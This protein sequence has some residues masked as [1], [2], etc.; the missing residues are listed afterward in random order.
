MFFTMSHQSVFDITQRGICLSDPAQQREITDL[1]EAE[2]IDV[3]FLDNGSCLFRGVRENDADDFSNLI[4]GWLMDLRR[5]GIAVVLVQH[6]GRN[7]AI[8]GTSKR[9]DSTF[10]I[11]RLDDAGQP[12]SDHGA[13]FITRFVKNRNA[14]QDPP[15]LDWSFTPDGSK[16]RITTRCAD[17]MEIFRGWILDGL[18][19]C[20]DLA[21]EMGCSKGKISKLATK[22]EKLGWLTKNGKKY[23][24]INW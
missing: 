8:R 20:T 16:T 22:A 21:E 19:T 14:S 3:L 11:I 7:G 12:D 9:E 18:D 1:C 6:A 17:E 2:K 15:P 10:W 5:R 24:I 23:Q 13:R 4:E